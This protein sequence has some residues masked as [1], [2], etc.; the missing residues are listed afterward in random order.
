V[1]ARDAILCLLS[2][3]NNQEHC[4]SRRAD[5]TKLTWG[6]VSIDQDKTAWL[7]FE[8]SAK[9]NVSDTIPLDEQNSESAKK[10][11]KKAIEA[12]Q[13][14]SACALQNDVC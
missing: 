14:R 10:P 7:R 1:Q 5:A 3:G 4:P 11:D 12:R 6:H 8:N 2:W 13:A 9:V